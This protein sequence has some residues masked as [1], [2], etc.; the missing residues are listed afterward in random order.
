LDYFNSSKESISTFLEPIRNRYIRG[1]QNRG[2]FP[3]LM[4]N[5]WLPILMNAVMCEAHK[6]KLNYYLLS[7]LDKYNNNE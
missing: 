5:K 7:E 6:D 1:L 4:N 2:L 3:K